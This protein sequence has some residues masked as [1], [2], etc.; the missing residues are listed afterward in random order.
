MQSALYIGSLRHRRFH[1]VT[2]E[3]SY[4]L[5]M[6]FLD[7]DRIPELMKISRA[8]GYN[9]WNWATFDDRD[10]F[11]DPHRTLR[12]RIDDDARQNGVIL[13]DGPIFLLT[14]LRY[15]GYNFNPV[16]FFYCCNAS[17]S[18][19]TI[20]AEVNNTFGETK[21]YWLSESMRDR[22]VTSRSYVFSKTFHVSPFIGPDC[23]YRFS[24]NN[25]GDS[26]SIQ[27]DVSQDG[28]P[29]FDATLTMHRL[30]WSAA[31][32]HR[33]LIRHPWMTAKVI[34]AIHWEAARLYVKKVPLVTR[35]GAGVSQ[36]INPKHSWPREKP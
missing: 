17:G 8:C 35:P 14:H 29:L 5:F 21:N 25:P 4:P 1:P 26:L 23:N 28:A 36:R 13:P 6:P 30:E 19:E 7:I 33:A 15:L 11:G 24:F 31:N 3:F 18:V 27:V 16:S 34:A 32:L 2:H 22:D 9:R 20:L 10:H 12:S